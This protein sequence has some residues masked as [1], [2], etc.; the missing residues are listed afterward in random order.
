MDPL[1]GAWTLTWVL[2]SKNVFENERIGSR[3]GCAPGTPP[4][5]A[6]VIG[7]CFEVFGSGTL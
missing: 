1:G 6:N 5:S 2:F 7:G 3:R 4:R